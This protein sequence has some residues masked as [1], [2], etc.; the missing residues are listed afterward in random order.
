MMLLSFRTDPAR[1]NKTVHTIH[2][3]CAIMFLFNCVYHQTSG[4]VVAL[5]GWGVWALTREGSGLCVEGRNHHLY[6]TSR[7]SVM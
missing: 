1:E 5:S 2:K 7:H 4:R 3:V 6:T